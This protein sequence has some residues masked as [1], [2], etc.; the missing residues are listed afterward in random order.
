MWGLLNIGGNRMARI[1]KINAEWVGKIVG[2]LDAREI[3]TRMILRE[4]GLDP[5]QFAE[6]DAKVPFAKYVALI[7]AAARHSQNPCFGLHLGARIDLLEAG[8]LG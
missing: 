6:P 8:L 1:R 3:P 5:K 7:E 2:L 4:V